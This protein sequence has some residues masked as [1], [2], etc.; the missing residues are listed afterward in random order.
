MRADSLRRLRS[1]R[2]PAP[3][4]GGRDVGTLAACLQLRPHH[5]LGNPFP[6]CEGAETAI[7]AC[8][9]PF[10]VA[11]RLS[12]RLDALRH[13]FRVLDEITLRIDHAGQQDHM[14]GEPMAAQGA[15]LVLATRIGE[16]DTQA[17]DI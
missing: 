17:S 12:R 9:H 8:N 7:A 6:P 16:L 10:A 15:Y 11:D 5:V 13:D 3:Q 4:P 14:V 1:T 2:L